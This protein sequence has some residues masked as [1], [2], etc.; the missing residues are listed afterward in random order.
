MIEVC[1]FETVSE[2]FRHVTNRKAIAYPRPMI[3]NLAPVF[4]VRIG[5]AHMMIE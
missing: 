1:N 4:R 5:A 3:G 2:R